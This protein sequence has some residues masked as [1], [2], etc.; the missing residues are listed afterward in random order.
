MHQNVHIFLFVSKKMLTAIQRQ[1][2]I[3]FLIICFFSN[4]IRKLMIFFGKKTKWVLVGGPDQRRLLKY[5][6]VENQYDPLER[7]VQNDTQ[8]LP[9]SINLALQQI[10]DFV[11]K[12]KYILLVL[13]HFL[14]RM[15]KMK[16]LLLV[17]GWFSY[18]YLI[19]TLDIIFLVYFYRCGMI[20]I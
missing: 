16:L 17:A 8:T 19:V 2:T 3:V 20:I 11:R 5:L 15:E 6:I 9:V 4:F 10:I 7:P 13:F 1:L 12:I 14:N 18:V